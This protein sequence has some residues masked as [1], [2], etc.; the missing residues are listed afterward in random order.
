MVFNDPSSVSLL[1]LFGLFKQYNFTTK[2]CHQSLRCL[3]LN[4]WPL[5]HEASFDNHKTTFSENASFPFPFKLENFFRNQWI[6]FS[7]FAS[8][9]VWQD[10]NQWNCVSNSLKY[11]PGQGDLF[12]FTVSTSQWQIVVTIRVLKKG[13]WYLNSWPLEFKDR[14][15]RQMNPVSIG[16]PC[17]LFS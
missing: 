1:K 8:F 2:I 7:K 9:Y 11:C 14:R 10:S 5:D 17:S 15:H 4:S 13:W 12:L 16:D 6:S 3:D